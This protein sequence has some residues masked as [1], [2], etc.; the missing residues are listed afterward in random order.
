MSETSLLRNILAAFK[1]NLVPGLILQTLAISIALAY[2]FWPA[3]HG[4][5]NFFANLKA[6]Y[7]SLYAL[8]ATA[9]FGGLIPFLYLK[10]T[11]QITRQAWMHATFYMVF[12]GYKGMEVD[13]FYQYQALWFGE[14]N[15]AQTIMTKTAVDQFIYSA[16]WSA[17]TIT[18][19]FLWKDLGFRWGALKA[20]IN[21]HLF[22]VQIPTVVV[23]NWMVWIP[24][25]SVIYLMP[26]P[27]QI[28]LFNLV[29]CFFVLLLAVLNQPG[30]EGEEKEQELTEV[31]D[32]ATPAS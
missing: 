14:G 5:F 19:L 10:L 8:I 6:E 15:D 17:P 3:S 24:A 32:A 20:C 7:G 2:F 4:V 26:S 1:Q 23:S 31:K 22:L 27:L 13:L 21:R 29:L 28:P 25:V 18:L 12:W 9:L 30:E 16:L 11:G